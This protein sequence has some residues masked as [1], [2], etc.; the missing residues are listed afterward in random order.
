MA[1]GRSKVVRWVA[2]ISCLAISCGPAPTPEPTPLQFPL[3]SPIDPTPTRAPAA[4]PSPAGTPPATPATPSAD[5]P[6]RE[7]TPTP[8]MLATSASVIATLT[9]QAIPPTF[10]PTATPRRRPVGSGA[11][12]VTRAPTRTPNPGGITLIALSERVYAG[13]AGT[14][15]IRTRPQATCTVQIARLDASGGRRVTAIDGATRQAGDDGVIAWIWAVAA[16]E[17][18][19]PATLRVTCAGLGAAEYAIEILR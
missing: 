8:D 6:T 16:D 2:I 9:A 11:G 4:S 14:L 15:T 5:Q 17:P 19:G 12:A 3:Q 10:P 18:A 1:I 7:S 13:A